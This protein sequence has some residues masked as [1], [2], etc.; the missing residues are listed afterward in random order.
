MEDPYNVFTELRV[1]RECCLEP[2]LKTFFLK[3]VPKKFF[4][5][6][7]YIIYIKYTFDIFH[8]YFLLRINLV[9]RYHLSFRQDPETPKSR[10]TMDKV[11]LSLERP[12]RTFLGVLLSPLGG[13]SDTY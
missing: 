3:Y 7:M 8:Y 6:Y 2:Y 5:F 9:D 11:H 1:F 12:I 13:R 4:F 10:G